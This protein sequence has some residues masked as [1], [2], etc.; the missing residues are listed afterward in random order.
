MPKFT[1]D[2]QTFEAS[3]EKN[4]LEVLLARGI[5]LPYF[6]WH[7]EMGSIGACRQC[8][9]LQ[10]RDEEDTQGRIVMSCMTPVTDGVVSRST[11]T[12]RRPSGGTSSKG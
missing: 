10:Y 2:G 5:H 7:P 3:S 12:T 8:A 6:C 1:V 11:P 9:V 4:L